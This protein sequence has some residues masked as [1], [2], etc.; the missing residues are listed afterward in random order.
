MPA[1]PA[2]ALLGD[3]LIEGA[4]GKGP[5]ADSEMALFAAVAGEG[6]EVL[7]SGRLLGC[8]IGESAGAPESF[9]VLAL[10]RRGANLAGEVVAP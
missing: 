1:A 8:G 3:P 9:R 5:H 10:R 2:V 6:C 4:I 7:L